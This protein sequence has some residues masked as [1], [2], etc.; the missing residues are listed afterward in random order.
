MTIKAVLFDLGGTLLH[1]HDPQSDERQRPFRHITRVGVGQL[2]MHLPEFGFDPADTSVLDPVI[3]RHIGESYQSTLQQLSGG[4]IESPIRA[5][6]AE[7]GIFVDDMQWETLRRH[8]YSAIDT[9]VMAREGLH[10]TL[11]ALK[12]EGYRLGLVSN[13]YWA[14]DLHDR[15]LLSHGVLSFFDV[16]VYSCD[17]P[18]IKPH[19]AIFLHALGLMD[20]RPEEAVYVGDRLEV[21]VAGAQAAGMKGIL[22][23]SPY[24]DQANPEGILPDAVIDQLPDLIPTLAR[25]QTY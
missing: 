21:D 3:D 5:A 22:I 25:L 23:R 24:A 12:E 11:S 15:H 6:L 14:S 19:P 9:I 18:V 13:T 16:R 2:C 10:E 1:Y 4:T 7:L 17:T 8:F 20:T